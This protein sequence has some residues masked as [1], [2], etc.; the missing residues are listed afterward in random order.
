MT[1]RDNHASL[2]T[3]CQPNAILHPHSSLAA[4]KE[5]IK[6]K[7]VPKTV[8]PTHTVVVLIPVN[9]TLKGPQDYRDLMHIKFELHF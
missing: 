2:V 5:S 1:D 9:L 4:S 8:V 7:F 3:G 6:M